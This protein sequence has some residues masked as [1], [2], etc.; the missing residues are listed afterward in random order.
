MTD[1][2]AIDHLVLAGPDLA[3]MSSMWREATGINPMPGGA[4]T[5]MGTRNELVGIDSTTYIELIGPDPDQ[6]ERSVGLGTGGP[7]VGLLSTRTWG[8]LVR[9]DARLTGMDFRLERDG[10]TG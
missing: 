10:G 8:G 5:D 9:S 6:P 7:V 2:S 3:M 1:F 4:H